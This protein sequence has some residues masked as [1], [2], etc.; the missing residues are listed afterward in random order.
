MHKITKSLTIALLL[1]INVGCFS[2]VSDTKRMPNGKPVSFKL[3][4]EDNEAERSSQ[5]ESA[6]T[7]LE[8]KIL[9]SEKDISEVYAENDYSGRPSMIIKFT[10]DCTNL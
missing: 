1:M 7:M 5:K 6:S 10:A 2:S 4:K 8:D 9:L 3:V